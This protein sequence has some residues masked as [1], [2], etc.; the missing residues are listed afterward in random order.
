[1]K[2]NILFLTLALIILGAKKIQC[3]T[4][5]L[6]KC[7]DRCYVIGTPDLCEKFGGFARLYKKIELRQRGAQVD[8][9]CIC[10]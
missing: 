6:Y 5:T 7:N 9:R 3:A 4:V 8:Y 1:M 10:R 2:K